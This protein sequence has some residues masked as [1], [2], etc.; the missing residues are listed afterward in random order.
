[1]AFLLRSPE[2]AEVVDLR[3]RGLTYEEIA[4]RTGLNERSV[5][6][7][8]EAIRLRMEARKWR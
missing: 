3:R 8:I 6:R 2:E 5:R 4:E 7:I 1:M